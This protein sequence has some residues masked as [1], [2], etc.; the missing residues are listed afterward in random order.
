MAQ[1]R[2]HPTCAEATWHLLVKM[3]FQPWTLYRFVVTEKCFF[4]AQALVFFFKATLIPLK[5]C[6]FWL[7]D[8]HGH[9]IQ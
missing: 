3:K 5:Y 1:G 4:L 7:L 6:C 8:Y 2:D 9:V